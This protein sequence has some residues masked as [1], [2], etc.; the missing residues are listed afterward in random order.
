MSS[1]K[2]TFAL[3]F[4]I[5]CCSVAGSS[6]FQDPSGVLSI[7]WVL[8]AELSRLTDIGNP[9]LLKNTPYNP[10]PGAPKTD[11]IEVGDGVKIRHA[12]WRLSPLT[13]KG[14]VIIL[15][16]RSEYIEKQFE[17]TANL[18][19]MGYD[20]LAFDWRG[21]GGSSRSLENT[22]VGYVDDF[23]EYVEDLM[24]ILQQVAL[25]DCR[26]P[27][28][29]LAHSTG[30]LVALMAAPKI[31]NKISRMV[32]CST[33][34][35][36]G[37]QPISEPLIR[38]LSGGLTSFGLGE[39]LLTGRD[40]ELPKWDR[41][42]N[43]HTN[44]KENFDRNRKFARD[45][46]ELCIGGATASWVF[47]AC[48]AFDRVKDP[49]F[50]SQ[51]TIPILMI[52]AGNDVVVRNQ[53]NEFLARQLRSGSLLTIEGARHEIWQELPIYREQLLAAFS[54]FVPGSGSD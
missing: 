34:L 4:K 6:N 50:H 53:E 12:Y 15:Q 9:L 24:E 18:L 2:A 31:G 52:N 42:T 45:F 54:A 48:K 32:L 26:G 36:I 43:I 20:V 10:V 28:H 39:A 38:L 11:V 5:D 7:I 37:K 40:P 47:A 46:P 13:R 23:D 35:G 8:K 1:F 14:T 44:S 3:H 21:Q 16:G 49:D 29:I 41:A 19:E 51:I 30:S 25:P 27:L 33:F 22:N 17:L